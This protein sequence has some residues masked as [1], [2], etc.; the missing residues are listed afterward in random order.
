MGWSANH[1]GELGSAE[2]IDSRDERRDCTLELLQLR[3]IELR[4][5]GELHLQRVPMDAVDAKL[6]VEVRARRDSGRAYV[7]D[8]LALSYPGYSFRTP[9]A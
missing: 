3:R 9:F 5:E 2:G 7:S 1:A 6:V 8:D 4:R